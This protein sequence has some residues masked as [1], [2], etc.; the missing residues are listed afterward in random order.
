[1]HLFPDRLQSP[2]WQWRL[3]IELERPR[4]IVAAL[5]CLNREAVTVRLK[6]DMQI[7]ESPHA[8]VA[9]VIA[10]VGEVVIP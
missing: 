3:Q 8:S 10:S 9:I 5:I 6:Y 4:L 1:M 7:S 2:L